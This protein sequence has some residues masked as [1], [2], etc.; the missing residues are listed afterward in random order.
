MQRLHLLILLLGLSVLQVHCTAGGQT[1]NRTGSAAT[2]IE[3]FEQGTKNAYAREVAALATGN[4]RLDNCLI[5]TAP[6]DHKNGS[7]ALRLRAGGTATLLG[8]IPWQNY[9]L[10]VQH[11]LYGTD[12]AAGWQLWYSTND[13]Q[14]Q[15]AGTDVATTTQTL[16]TASFTIP[17]TGTIQ[18]Q[19]RHT[20]GGRINIDD[21]SWGTQQAGNEARQVAGQQTHSGATRDDNMAMGNPSKASTTNE[22]NYLLIKPQYTLSYNAG[23]GCANWVSWHLSAAWKG[24]AKRCNCFAAEPTLPHSFF[25]VTTADYTGSGFDRGHLCPSA[26]RDGS[27]EDNAAT[28]SMANMVPQAPRLNGV[29]WEALES[30]CRTLLNDDHELYVIAGAYGSG[31]NGR[32]GGTTLTVGGH[33]TVPA[34]MW[35][36]VVVLNNGNDDVQRVTT[37]TRVIAVDMPNV[38]SVSSQNWNYYRTTVDAI[39]AATGLNLLSNVPKDVQAV[40]EATKDNGPAPLRP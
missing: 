8:S 26:D 34:R 18:L 11:A 9:T 17:A 36:V 15:Q 28:F 19:I 5:G 3:N 40:I 24:N 14:W 25:T 37:N 27:E 10:T 6:Q 38:Q 7:K 1:G 22:N 30:Y 16:S 13:G 2:G 39:E 23:R 21:V 12:P 35:K 20:G 32:L 29:T 33:I 4:W 31:G